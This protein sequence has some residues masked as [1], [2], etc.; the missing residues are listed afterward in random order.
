[1]NNQKESLSSTQPL[2]RT[3]GGRSKSNAI[4][5]PSISLPKGGGAIKGIDEKF[6]VNAVN[7]TASFS[8]PFPFSSSRNLTPDLVL[9]YNS[10]AGNGPFGLGWTLSLPSIKRKTD[11]G[12][13][14]YDDNHESDVFMFIGTEDLVPEFDKESVGDKEIFL[15][16]ENDRHIIKEINSPDNKFRVRFYKPRIEGLFARIERWRSKNDGHIK[17]RIISKDNITTLLGWSDNSRISDPN[18]PEKVFEWLPE[19]VFDDKGNCYH[20][21]YKEEDAAGLDKCRLHNYN[22]FNEAGITYTNK[23]LKK[24]LYGCKSPYLG[25]GNDFPSDDQ[26]FFETIFDYGEFNTDNLLAVEDSKEETWSYR[27]DAFSNYKSGFEIRTTRLCKRALFIHKFEGSNE[28]PGGKAI[29]RSVNFQYD[30]NL[31]QGFTFL[32]S[33][34]QH[35]YTKYVGNDGGFLYSQKSLPPM[36]F[37]YQ[38]HEWN[39]DIKNAPSCSFENAPSGLADPQYLFTDLYN[40]GLPGILT[41]QDRGWYYKENNGG[42]EFAKAT[43]ISEKPSFAGLGSR[44]H[45]MDLDADGGKQLVSLSGDPKGYFELNNCD[46][47]QPFKTFKNYPNINLQDPNTRVFDLNGDGKPEIVITEES[48]FTWYENEGR[49]GY[50]KSHRVAKPFDENSGPAIVFNDASQSIYLADMSGDGLTDIV[51]IRNG[52]VCYWPNLGYGNFG[53]KILMD[54]APYFDNFETFNPSYL[55]LADIDGSGTTD[56]I[57]L[58]KRCFKCWKNL[59]GNSFT[60]NPFEIT[61]LPPISS[62]SNITVTDFLGNGVACIVWSSTLPG[63]SAAPLKFI[64]LMNSKKPHVMKKYWNNMGKEVEFEYLPSTNFY[65]KDKKNGNPWITKLHFP[66]H[67]ISKTITRDLITKYEFISTYKYHHG[68]YDNIEREFRGFGMVEQIDSE[69]FKYFEKTSATNFQSKDLH[70]D[71][72]ITKTWNHTGVY[73][74][75]DNILGLYSN[76][77]WYNSKSLED[78]IEEIYEKVLPDAHFVTSPKIDQSFIT[79]LSEQELREGIRACKGMPLRTEL[80]SRGENEDYLNDI[81]YTVSDMNCVIELVQPK[82]QNHHAVFVVKES[83]AI[84]YSYERDLNDPRISHNLNIKLDEY[85]NVLESASVVYPRLNEHSYLP[86]DVKEKQKSTIISF[87][88][89]SF[90]NNINISDSYRLPLPYTVKSYEI[91]GLQPGNEPLDYRNKFFSLQDFENIIEDS[92]TMDYLN[93]TFSDG[94][95]NRL[96]EQVN[97]LYLKDNLTGPLNLGKLESKAFPYESYQ[98]AYTPAII[99]DI[100]GDSRVSDSLMEEGKF[101]HFNDDEK[102]WVP[103]GTIQMLHDDDSFNDAQARFFSPLSFKDPYGA[104]TQIS[105]Y[106]DYY[107]FI[108]STTDALGNS[109]SV[110]KFNFRTLA[111]QEMK[112]IN[113]NSSEVITDELGLPKSMSILGE[114]DNNNGITEWTGDAELDKIE[115]YF[116]L[117]I[118]S[119]LVDASKDLLGKSTARFIYD[120]DSFQREGKPIVVS[121]IMREEHNNDDSKVQLSFEYTGGLGEIVMKKVQAEPG[122]AKRVTIISDDE[123]QVEEIDTSEQNPTELR[124]LGNGR[125]ILNNK[126][127]P[128]KQYEPYF[129]TTPFYEDHKE[130][131]E[132]G[133]TSITYYDALDRPVKVEMPDGTFSKIEFDSWQKRSFDQNDTVKDSQWYAEK[134]DAASSNREKSVAEGVTCHYNT[135]NIEHYDTLGRPILSLEYCAKMVKD[136]VD[137]GGAEVFNRV[138][139][140]YATKVDLDVEG[141][142]KK[143][144]NAL[145]NRVVTYKYDMLGNM[146]YQHCFDSGQRWTLLNILGEPL[147]TWDERDHEFSYFYDPLHRPLYIHVKGGDGEYPLD[148]IFDRVIYGEEISIDGKSDKELNLRGKVYR[149]FDTGGMVETGEYDVKEQPLSIT[150]RLAEDY[151]SVVNW[152]DANVQCFNDFLEAE[153]FTF[154][155]KTDALGR[156]TEQTTPDKSI[157]KPFYNESGL[158]NGEKV[159][160][161]RD[162]DFKEY[163]KSID[164]N[165]K[166]QRNKVEYGNSVTTFYTYDEKT[167]RL[168]NLLTK[169][170]NGTKKLQDLHYTYDPIGNIT[171]I[172]DF[173]NPTVYHDGN[174]VK[175]LSTY[176]YDSL[177]RLIEA[178]G[179]ENSASLTFDNRDNYS[180]IP[181]K[182]KYKNAGPMVVWDYKQRYLYDAVGNIINMKHV[183]SGNSWTRDYTYADKSNRLL[184]TTVGTHTYNYDYHEKHGFCTKMPHLEGMSW[185]FKEELIKTNRQ[186]VNSGTPETTYYQYDSAGQRLRKVTER[187]SSGDSSH[188]KKDERYYLDGY[189]KYKCYHGANNGLIRESL[190]LMDEDHRFVTIENRNDVDD[191]T[192]KHLV[193][194]QLHNHLGSATLELTDTA[195]VISY[196]EYH[197]FG[198]TAYQA[199]NKDIKAA[200]KRYRYSGKERD[201]ESGFY[202]YGARYYAP[203]LGRWFNCDPAGFVD[204]VN[205]YQFVSG[206]PIKYY[207][208]DGQQSKC[209]PRNK[210]PENN[211][212]DANGEQVGQTVNLNPAFQVDIYTLHV[213]Q[214]LKNN[215]SKKIKTLQDARIEALA[216][217]PLS[218]EERIHDNAMEIANRLISRLRVDGTVEVIKPT[219]VDTKNGKVRIKYDSKKARYA[220]ETENVIKTMKEKI[221][222]DVSKEMF[223]KYLFKVF[224]Y[225]DL[226]NDINTLYQGIKRDNPNFNQK[227]FILKEKLKVAEEIIVQEKIKQKRWCGV[228]CQL[229]IREKVKWSIHNP[230]SFK[231]AKELINKRNKEVDVL[232]KKNKLRGISTSTISQQKN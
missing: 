208:L 124:W 75:R 87:N 44:L 129:S 201:E 130:L 110:S 150:R 218:R 227:E 231:G 77:Y 137:S 117:D 119:D 149:H 196:E 165:E 50:S 142:L 22:R 85:G 100:Y 127:N 194:Y 136:I 157:I 20:Y 138:E 43:Q 80:F 90:T 191:G 159:K 7:G 58:G 199:N 193:R 57:Y 96:I 230:K 91:K 102:W 114:G 187:E 151:K 144:V 30:D 181:F 18:N 76:D 112:D 176:S 10:G 78:N 146:V 108:E 74:D 172:E 143:V 79:N 175:P 1:M 205:L 209:R 168:T 93:T 27:Q 164:Y 15:K 14:K 202:Y 81:P 188:T 203:W 52:E 70:Q 147:K 222:Q 72:V 204:G 56:I 170:E 185:N 192:D 55:Q 220:S 228:R 41:E 38:E 184:S 174:A 36:E 118:T 104:I 221:V 61:D 34:S 217:Y 3:E 67:C 189:E 54:N 23:Y 198:T 115:D 105:Y 49:E 25:F 163:I 180:D 46:G 210:H 60:N 190:S 171:H 12:L 4:E 9:S 128:V 32:R 89:I 197:P 160:Q 113:D 162:S 65:L 135:P 161:E 26:Y 40:E 116:S 24:I 42:G 153:E 169:D 186:S 134:T 224:P 183:A 53:A 31:E 28:L 232:I 6:S 106:K 122:V 51:R 216:K 214:K 66:V 156:I 39:S 17:W 207:D 126:G 71:P 219:Y 200:S 155:N 83:E 63:D 123:F 212:D 37:E 94:V 88:Q 225:L 84:T 95:T 68:Y 213:E 173:A 223:D 48:A 166:R 47:W 158:L 35:G 211:D 140:E 120:F 13:P 148:N 21:K 125:V 33:F 195:K 167:F 139:E 59:N 29:V 98:L 121:T 145:G 99:A 69:P 92:T 141:N 109:T 62:Q 131:V 45:L 226:L 154:S 215:D 16:D 132:T 73:N 152:N 206:N 178:T 229:D 2:L 97:T 101:T 182:S 19:F 5:V 111:P 82:G 86:I 177:Y 8:I 179:R 11:K 133:V 64:D 103:S 107:L